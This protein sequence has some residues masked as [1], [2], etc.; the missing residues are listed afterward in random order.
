MTTPNQF[1]NSLPPSDA[2]L[3][4]VINDSA[5]L[6]GLCNLL[7]RYLPTAQRADTFFYA[8][9]ECKAPIPL[10]L[11]GDKLWLRKEFDIELLDKNSYKRVTI[12][13]S[14]MIEE[15]GQCYTN[16]AYCEPYSDD[17]VY[18]RIPLDAPRITERY[19][20]NFLITLIKQFFGKYNRPRNIFQ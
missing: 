14:M 20:I 3:K 19:S 11:I 5:T 12:I 4:M 6:V 16:I 10:L 1:L 9:Y 18:C 2:D 7:N 13:P 15:D 8:F 17:I